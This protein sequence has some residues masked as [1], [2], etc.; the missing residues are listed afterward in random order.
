MCVCASRVHV[1]V[2]RSVH[3]QKQICLF[4]TAGWLAAAAKLRMVM[5]MDDL[6][7]ACAGSGPR[8]DDAGG[9]KETL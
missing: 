6:C 9:E 2:H 8:S 4:P 5:M 1:C 7:L 3:C